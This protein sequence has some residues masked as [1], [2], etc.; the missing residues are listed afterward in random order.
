MSQ[1]YCYIDIRM[2]DSENKKYIVE[3]LKALQEL[4]HDCGADI[5]INEN[6]GINYEQTCNSTCTN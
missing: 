1:E 6:K 5:Y 3:Q 4:M 2:A